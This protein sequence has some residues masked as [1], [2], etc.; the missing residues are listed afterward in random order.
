METKFQTSF[1][2]KRPLV[3]DPKIPT[4][5][6]RTGNASITMVI[7]SLLFIASLG[8]AVFTIVWKNVLLKS[9]ANYIVQ[10]K[11]SEKRFNI[12]LIED[13]KKV[14]TKIDVGKKLFTSHLAVS[15]IFPIM[16]QL[17]IESVQFNSFQ[18]SAPTND[19]DGVK[20]SIKGTAKDYNSIAFQ[21]DVFGSANKY[22]SLKSIKNPI[23]ADLI[24]GPSGQISFSFTGT[25]NPQ[26]ILYEKSLEARLQAEQ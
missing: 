8:G 3:S 25:L 18:F 15:E 12:T 22:G 13:L 16:N 23:I 4:V 11:E 24:E 17:A 19:E 14:N 5:H 20:V 6:S 2:P 7:G 9:Q 1:I 26:D 10:L 21:S